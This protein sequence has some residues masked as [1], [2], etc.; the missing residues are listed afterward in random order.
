[1]A[2]RMSR[3]SSMTSTTLWGDKGGISLSERQADREGRALSGLA[4]DVDRPARRFDDVAANPK[5]EPE[6]SILPRG[7]RPLEPLEQ[8]LPILRVDSDAVV[9]DRDERLSLIPGDHDLDRFPRTELDG[10]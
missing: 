4:H 3:S 2:S 5:A 10:V 7:D 6:A 8:L 1:M 9:R